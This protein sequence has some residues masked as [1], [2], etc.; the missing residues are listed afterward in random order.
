MFRKTNSK[1]KIKEIDRKR[2]NLKYKPG[3]PGV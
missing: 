3:P 1:Y 2:I